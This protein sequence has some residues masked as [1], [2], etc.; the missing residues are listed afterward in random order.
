MDAQHR[1]GGWLSESDYDKVRHQVAI[2]CTDVVCYR[3]RDD[4]LQIGLIERRVPV[5]DDWQLGWAL[6]GGRV[7]LHETVADAIARHVRSTL[8]PYSLARLDLLEVDEPVAV[9]QYF[10]WRRPGY[11]YDPRQHSIALTYALEVPGEVTPQGEALDF[12]WFATDAL[13]HEI[14]FG[15]ARALH[16]AVHCLTS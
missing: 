9:E 14:G 3:L 2:A 8:G 6:V 15:Q 5:A 11:A 10:P 7:L 13:P 12:R 1:P 16:R 4:G